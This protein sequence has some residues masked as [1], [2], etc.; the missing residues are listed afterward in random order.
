MGEGLV[1]I[2]F[3]R[4]DIDLGK[5]L[6]GQE[7]WKTDDPQLT[8]RLRKTFA[9]DR[10]RRRVPLDLIVEAAPG[11]PLRVTARA[12]SGAEC[13]LESSQDLQEAIRHPLTAE[14]LAE[15]FGR[16][17]GTAY[18][19]RRVDARIEGRP[20]APLSVLGQLRRELIERLD[21]SAVRRPVLQVAAE[22]P[23]AAM[24]A[25]IRGPSRVSCVENGEVPLSLRERAGVRGP[26]GNAAHRNLE[27][28]PTSPHPNPLPEGEGDL[29]SAVCEL[30]GA[31]SPRWIVLCRR[32]EQVRPAVAAGAAEIIVD[33]PDAD[34]SAEA[35][36]QARAA[37]AAVLLAAP[38]MQKP[39]EME[40]VESL[41]R[42]GA[43]GLLVRNL[44]AAALCAERGVP[45]VA[46]FSLHAANEL[47]VDWLRRLGARRV[48]AAYD[49]S[50]EQII[51]LAAAVPAEWLEVVV[52][53]HIPMFHTQHCV[54]CAMLPAG[55]DRSDCGQPC[56]RGD[57]RLRDRLGV[58]HPLR[59]DSL[60]RI[61][62]FDG[63]VRSALEIAPRLL[64]LGVRNLR[65]ELLDE[66]ADEVV[67]LLPGP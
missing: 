59:A 18:V 64:A 25:A 21:A 46:D 11:R 31:P 2:T 62:V 43:D 47:T 66:G 26:R 3:G 6:P 65:I 32:L 48:T 5:V 19:L 7:V 63:R 44:A 51:A 57:A 56:R 27:S 20:M 10:S 36:S 67:R 17:G 58:D 16:L 22:S 53:Q 12:D 41:L 34:Q 33:L 29:K 39:G 50:P 42:L 45:F 8:R 61:T 52:R 55:C 9:G 49:C 15:Q 1:E 4:E 13:S 30:P 38:R 14:V 24:R 23:L 35:I 28:S 40:A 60:C 54:F 37:G